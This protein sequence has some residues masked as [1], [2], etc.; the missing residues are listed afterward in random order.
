MTIWSMMLRTCWLF[1]QYG[2][3][4]PF[5]YTLFY[6]PVPSWTFSLRHIWR[7]TWKVVN[8]GSGS[9]NRL[10][11]YYWIQP[12]D[13]YDVVVT[14]PLNIIWSVQRYVQKGVPL[15]GKS[16]VPHNFF[17]CVAD[18]TYRSES[19]LCLSAVCCVSFYAR[20]KRP[21]TVIYLFMLRPDWEY[22][23]TWVLSRG[24]AW[25]AKFSILMPRGPSCCIR[26]KPLQD[27]KNDSNFGS[28]I[29]LLFL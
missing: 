28:F 26:K 25:F 6:L 22:N 10:C 3:L 17:T 27:P 18:P 24:W 20:S 29:Y 9:S 16:I 19:S 14:R 21:R 7:L 2:I 8:V 23:H 5:W 12:M 15:F 11:Q 13:A 4:L 1:D